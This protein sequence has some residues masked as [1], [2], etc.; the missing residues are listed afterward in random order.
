MSATL[1][2]QAVGHAFGDVTALERV[3]FEVPAGEILAIVGPSGCGKSTL[4]ELI[5]GLTEPTTGTIR[6][7]G[8]AGARGRL[9]RC[10]YMPQT[11]SLLPWYT[12]IDN[13]CL[14]LRNR[15]VPKAEAR[16]KA[17]GHFE[18]F[19]LA[20]F[21]GSHPGEL[22]GGMRQ[23]VA[24]MRTLLSEKDVLLLDE[25]FAALDAITRAELQ[26]WLRSVITA[27]RRTI[28]LVTHDL[29]EA[30]YLGDRVAVMS[31]RPG[32][33]VEL[34][35]S[36]RPSSPSRAE[37]VTAPEFTTIRQ[38]ILSLLIGAGEPNG[39]PR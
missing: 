27:D 33:F 11:D 23:R 22:S 8:E 7:D 18:R 9:E 17:A 24:F 20:G 12:A 29:E 39:R 2:G 30:L 34:V 26:E 5:C 25:P 13:A 19:G 6:I 3:G 21:E 32:R 35:E 15:G 16:R 28:V 1:S 14:A 31:P 36:P 10:A 37:T 38:S 4:L